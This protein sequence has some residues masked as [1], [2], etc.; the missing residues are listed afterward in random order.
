MNKSF[1]LDSEN[2]RELAVSYLKSVSLTMPLVVEIKPYKRNRS[3]A[4]NKLMWMWFQVI[5]DDLGYTQDEVYNEM[6][7]L[8]LPMI[9][10]RRF[11]GEEQQVRL[12]T[13]KLK[14]HEFREFLNNI[15]L[16]AAGMGIIL[17]KPEDLMWEA[18]GV[19]R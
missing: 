1:K 18:M 8:Y 7:E 16:F 10:M 4:Q 11:D 9:A 13:S 19:K 14:V 17:P 3:A 12:T 6:S 5:G 15:D 2:K